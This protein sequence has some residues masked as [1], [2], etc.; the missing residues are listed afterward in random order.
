[1]KI[2]VLN[3]QIGDRIVA[4]CN[5]KRQACTVK[6]VLDSGQGSITLTVYTSEHYRSSVSR[7]VQF[8][9]DALVDLAS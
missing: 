3:I 7:A 2:Q 5:N 6:Q 9:R 8:Q 4:Y 1:M